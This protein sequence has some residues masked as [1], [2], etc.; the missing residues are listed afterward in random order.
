MN[1]TQLE[2]AAVRLGDHG[3]PRPILPKSVR[4]QE[5]DDILREQLEYLIAHVSDKIVPGCAECRRYVRV[6]SLLLQIFRTS[7]NEGAQAREVKATTSCRVW[8]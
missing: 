5:T 2:E 8:E 6:R 4:L 1:T 3:I 7:N